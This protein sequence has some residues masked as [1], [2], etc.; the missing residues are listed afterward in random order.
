[1][2]VDQ[3]VLDTHIAKQYAK[4]YTG[5]A[6]EDFMLAATA[7]VHRCPLWTL[8]LKHYPMADIGLFSA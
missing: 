8:N 3:W 5:I 2:K 1:M 6:L 4:A 7:H